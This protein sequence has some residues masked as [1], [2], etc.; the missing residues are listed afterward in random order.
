MPTIAPRA[1][2]GLVPAIQVFHYGGAAV[3]DARDK[4]AHD[5]LCKPG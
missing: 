5:G 4:P 3:V 2:A 1:T